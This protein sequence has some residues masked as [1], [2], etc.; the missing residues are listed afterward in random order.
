ML[1][2]VTVTFN[3][4]DYL[5]PF[6]TCCLAQQ[7]CDFE[8]LI[9]DNASSDRTLETVRRFVD[10]RINVLANNDNVGYSAACN[11]GV[12]HF[13]RLGVNELLFINNDTEFDVELF[14]TLIA[15]R[16]IYHANAVTPRI[17]YFG[18]PARDWYAG[19]QFIFWKG[20]QGAHLQ[21]SNRQSDALQAPQW[22][23]VA[24]GCCVLFA[25]NT[26][27]QI[28]LF[29][30]AYFVYFEDTDFFLRMRRAGL[31]LLYLPRTTVAHKIS[32]STGGPQSDFS[33]RY[34]QR[35]QI[36][37]LRKHF[38]RSVLLMQ[39]AILFAKATLRRLLGRD[40]SHQYLLRLRSMREG[41]LMS[42][43][44]SDGRIE[45]LPRQPH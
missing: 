37:A 22:T 36:Y 31:R 45:P 29:D 23:E 1:G 38:S 6:L 34:H 44:Q 35:N 20:F 40:D 43:P 8:L 15:Q 28:G 41:F 39:L 26:F 42:L 7:A 27:E 12:R 14:A 4:E 33:I 18:D 30:P 17:T 10:S 13:A 3:A 32:L 5:S 25:L 11:Q 24:P 16:R 19:G 9:I 2:V 21:S